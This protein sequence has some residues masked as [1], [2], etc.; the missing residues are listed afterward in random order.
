MK[1]INDYTWLY[2]TFLTA[3]LTSFG[4][5][6]G[7]TLFTA[8]TAEAVMSAKEKFDASAQSFQTDTNVDSIFEV[9]LDG[10]SVSEIEKIISDGR[11]GYFTLAPSDYHTYADGFSQGYQSAD[12]EWKK[13]I[14]V[15]THNFKGQA[16]VPYLQIF[17]EDKFGGVVRLKPNGSTDAPSTLTHLK[18]P[19]GTEYYKLD[20]NGD[21]SYDNEAFKVYGKQ[22]YPK[23][24][25]QVKLPDGVAFGTPEAEEFLKSCWTFKTHVPLAQ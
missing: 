17:Y 25:T 18:Q 13:T 14:K 16:I 2:F 19:H 23:S 1:V 6:C 4:V 20:P 5:E 9:S 15:S 21:L 10:K 22:A 3:P 8:D 7:D 24:P 12:G 11:D